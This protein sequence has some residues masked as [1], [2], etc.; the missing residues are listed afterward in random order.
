MRA[1]GMQKVESHGARRKLELTHDN[2]N[3]AATP[4]V[5][6]SEDH[7]EGREYPLLKPEGV[8]V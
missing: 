1:E 2:V 4:R 5:H 3:W 6:R 7:M 8:K